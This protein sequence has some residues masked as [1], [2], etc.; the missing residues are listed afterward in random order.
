M[1]TITK[2]LLFLAIANLIA[3]LAFVTGVVSAHDISA[4]YVTL[5]A[6]AIFSGLFLLAHMLQKETER[7]NEEQKAILS[8]TAT[9][10]PSRSVTEPHP[11]GR[12]AHGHAH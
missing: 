5:P 1:S 12:P 10:V 3:G 4:L 11:I 2:A 6:G 8:R 7:Y 9:S